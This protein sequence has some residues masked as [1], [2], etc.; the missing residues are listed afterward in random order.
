MKQE[1][2]ERVRLG[3]E[4]LN[5]ICTEVYSEFYDGETRMVA[6]KLER[7]IADAQTRHLRDDLNWGPKEEIE[8]ALL[9][10]VKAWLE[11]HNYGE[12]KIADDAVNNAPYFIIPPREWE[13]FIKH[14]TLPA[15]KGG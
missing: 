5:Q 14:G 12:T 7:R 9:Q 11:R 1:D 6:G 4:E 13:A 8:K 10:K 15:L 2:I 3:E